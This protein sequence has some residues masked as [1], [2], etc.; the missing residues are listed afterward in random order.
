MI[1][2]NTNQSM[3]L[4]IIAIILI[5]LLC[6]QGFRKGLLRSI[7]SLV[8]TILSYYLAW[9]I[10]SSL[11]EYFPLVSSIAF[12][13]VP[14]VIKQTETYQNLIIHGIDRIIWFLIMFFALR[15]II[16]I[17]DKI[18]KQIHEIPGIHM[19][20]GILGMLFGFL[21]SIV[22]IVVL[23]ILLETPL[24]TGGKELVDNSIVS[25]IKEVSTNIFSSFTT[26][27][28]LMD[29]VNELEDNIDSFSQDQLQ[30]IQKY[31]QESEGNDVN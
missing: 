3:I 16:W 17:L 9:I 2:L 25:P 15:I 5:A 20:S 10:S 23:A 4:N 26:P 27:L 6:I 8:G 30:Q 14:E 29:S 31:L 19:I 24:F 7:L 1:T 21:E 18:L 11:A 13:N 28:K 22:W 12:E